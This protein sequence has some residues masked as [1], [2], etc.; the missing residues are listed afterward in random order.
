MKSKACLSEGGGEILIKGAKNGIGV[1]DTL[2]QALPT[3][4]AGILLGAVAFT[5]DRT[6]LEQRTYCSEAPITPLCS[7]SIVPGIGVSL[8]DT[9]TWA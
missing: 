1:T 6:K 4:V 3:K 9:G 7:R 5:A 2:Q 8:R